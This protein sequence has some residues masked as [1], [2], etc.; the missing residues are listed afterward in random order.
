[1]KEKPRHMK[2]TLEAAI[3]AFGVLAMAEERLSPQLSLFSLKKDHW[4]KLAA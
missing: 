3:A 4:E 2:Q 1:M